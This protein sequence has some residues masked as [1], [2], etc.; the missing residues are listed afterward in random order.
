MKKVDKKSM[1]FDKSIYELGIG[2]SLKFIIIAILAFLILL[3]PVIFTNYNFQTL[4]QLGDATGGF[5]NPI[6]GISAALLTFLAF[7]IQYKANE[8]IQE[9]FS[10]QQF[11]VQ[12]YNMLNIHIQNVNSMEIANDILG[13]KCFVRMFYE[14]KFIYLQLY[15]IYNTNKK[16]F[17]WDYSSLQLCDLAYKVFFFGIGNISNRVVLKLIDKEYHP[18]IVLLI[19]VLED[20]QEMFES[21]EE[22]NAI[23]VSTEDDNSMFELEMFYY[24]F[25]GHSTRLGHY[26][27][28]LFQSVSYVVNSE[29]ITDRIDKYKYLKMIR[30]QLSNHEQLLL[31]YNS[32]STFGREWL[33]NEYFTTH[34]MIKN[35][36]LELADFGLQ[37]KELLGTLNS[38]NEFIFEWDEII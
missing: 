15:D 28:N 19:D 1:S 17:C 22:E 20:V 24:P 30:A 18:I 5:L 13:R 31:Y 3:F 38:F 9:Q 33:N 23:S 8:Q 16:E 12:F 34:R 2:L 27:R 6:I 4:G 36:P 29:V 35:I 10:K 26:F 32:L 11:D 14:F 7:Y 37:P 25:D 21:P